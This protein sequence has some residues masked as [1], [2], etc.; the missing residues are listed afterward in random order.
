MYFK[1][2]KP[3]ESMTGVAL[4]EGETIEKKIQ[5]I[6]NNKEPITD[7]APIIYTERKDGVQ[8]QYDIRSDRF[9]I[10]IEA[11]DKVDKAYKAKREQSIKDRESKKIETKTETGEGVQSTAN[12]SD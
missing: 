1:Q 5:R 6:V 7:G 2:R 3:K 10:A 8:P 4:F 12:T 11:M 9:D